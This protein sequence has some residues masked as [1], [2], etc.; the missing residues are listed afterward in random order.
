MNIKHDIL[1]PVK[2]KHCSISTVDQ[3]QKIQAPSEIRMSDISAKLR[4]IYEKMQI[5]KT[6]NQPAKQNSVDNS[7]K[8]YLDEIS[9]AILAEYYARNQK[10]KKLFE[11]LEQIKTLVEILLH[12]KESSQKTIKQCK[13]SS[14]SI[15]SIVRHLAYMA[16]EKNKKSQFHE[17]FNTFK[18]DKV[19]P[20]QINTLDTLKQENI[21]SLSTDF[22][23]SSKN[24]L[25]NKNS[26]DAQLLNDFFTGVR[27]AFSFKE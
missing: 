11:D 17:M 8:S 3:I 9:R 6:H 24:S 13:S 19:E 22:A 26:S 14:R 12:E 21:S 15:N 27:R 20:I 7:I 25:T 18:K 16:P 5:K 10:E 23:K 1:N 2:H 4:Y